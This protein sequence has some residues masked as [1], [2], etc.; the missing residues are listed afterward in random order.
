MA[1]SS[2]AT[3]P[4]FLLIF[5]CLYLL[6]IQIVFSIK[7]KSIVDIMG[8]D[9]SDFDG[10]NWFYN[11]KIKTFLLALICLGEP[12]F[13]DSFF[14]EGSVFT[15]KSDC[16]GLQCLLGQFYLLLS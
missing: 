15:D 2:F 7:L 9:L 4:Q 3:S 8:V 6:L 10:I 5:D 14:Y 12:N 16:R 1:F 11:D 13:V